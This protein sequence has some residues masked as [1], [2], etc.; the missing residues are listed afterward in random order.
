MEKI[1]RPSQPE[2]VDTERLQRRRVTLAGQVAFNLAA[3]EQPEL[4]SQWLEM[5][6]GTGITGWMVAAL[7]KIRQRNPQL[8]DATFSK[9]LS[10]VESEPRGAP[11]Q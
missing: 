10:Q 11:T 4:A 5:K 7:E 6:L 9:A 1:T 8:A 2:A 3:Q